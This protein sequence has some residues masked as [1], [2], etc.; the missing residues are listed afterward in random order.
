MRRLL[1]KV[2]SEFYKLG[3]RSSYRQSSFYYKQL[4]DKY[5][6][7]DFYM[8]SYRKAKEKK[9][10]YTNNEILY[11]TKIKFGCTISDTREIF[12]TPLFS[13]QDDTFNPITVLF[14]KTLIG[15]HKVRCEMFFWKE[16]LYSLNYTFPYLS[17]KDKKDIISVIQNKYLNDS[18]DFTNQKIVDQNGNLIMINDVNSF[19]IY[20]SVPTNIIFREATTLFEANMTNRINKEKRKAK[21]LYNR[22]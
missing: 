7:Y 3:K 10:L 2:K 11:N 9:D 17:N 5:N 8:E 22:L 4:V 15:G 6:N 20:Y 16:K 13:N 14:Y 1:N 19:E 12:G 18:I 21:Q